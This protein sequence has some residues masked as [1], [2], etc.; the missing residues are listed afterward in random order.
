[1][2]QCRH[3]EPDKKEKRYLT[4]R[5]TKMSG[6]IGNLDRG[7]AS[8]RRAVK[9]NESR[10]IGAR[11]KARVNHSHRKRAGDDDNNAMGSQKR[12]RDIKCKQWE[13]RTQAVY[14]IANKQGGYIKNHKRGHK[15]NRN[16][17]R[18]R[19]S[20]SSIVYQIA[21]WNENRGR[22]GRSAKQHQKQSISSTTRWRLA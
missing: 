15:G 5:R 22:S 19:N 21:Q 11:V 7:R 6:V 8:Q 2:L 20:S 4:F 9:Q 13:T 1:M 16:S 3:C 18:N 17:N 12:Y 14:G 10:R